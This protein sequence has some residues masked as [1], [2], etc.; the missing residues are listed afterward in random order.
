MF[1][2]GWLEVGV[3]AIV[4]LLIFGPKKIPELGNAL[5]KTLRGFKEELNHTDDEATSE[6]EQE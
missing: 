4:A 2:L 6:K 1:G 5:G 3:I